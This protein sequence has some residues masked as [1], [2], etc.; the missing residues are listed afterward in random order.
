MNLNVRRRHC[1]RFELFLAGVA[2]DLNAIAQLAV[3]LTDE[4]VSVALEHR[5]VGGRPRLLP[6]PLAGQ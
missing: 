2:G 5:R 1:C 6:E 4:L 3:D